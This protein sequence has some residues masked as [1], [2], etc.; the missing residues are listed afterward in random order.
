MRLFYSSTQARILEP[1]SPEDIALDIERLT[2][3]TTLMP[4]A[5]LK[6]FEPAQGM[7]LESPLERFLTPGGCSAPSYFVGSAMQQIGFRLGNMNEK[8]ER[9]RIAREN[10]ALVVRN[11]VQA[12]TKSSPPGF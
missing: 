12:V 6:V 7:S 3:D 8:Y 5:S 4:D 2:T 9:K 10:V 11:G 1:R